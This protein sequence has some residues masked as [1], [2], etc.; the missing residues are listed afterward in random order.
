MEIVHKKSVIGEPVAQPSTSTPPGP[1]E[2]RESVL[3]AAEVSR[4]GVAV[5]TKHR[6]R[7]LSSHGAR[8]DQA[9]ALQLGE[10]ILVTVGSLAAIGATVMWVADG[11]AGLK[12]FEPVDPNAARSKTF[13]KTSLPNRDPQPSRPSSQRE[14]QLAGWLADLE[15]SYD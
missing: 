6:L 7:D 14:T 13:V 12:F 1:R 4:F 9:D 2:V 11:A 5:I 3:L 15:S 10:T 8:I